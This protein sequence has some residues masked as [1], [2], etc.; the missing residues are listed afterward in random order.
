M[1]FPSDKISFAGISTPTAIVAIAKTLRN[2]KKMIN[3]FILPSTELYNY[4]YL[5]GKIYIN[6]I[7]SSRKEKNNFQT[8]NLVWGSIIGRLKKVK[9]R[10]KKY[11]S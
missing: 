2:A 10:L 4:H 5:Y 8:S 1:L 9:V 11:I 3:G 6:H 7:S